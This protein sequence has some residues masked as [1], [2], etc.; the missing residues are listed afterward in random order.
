MSP[1]IIEGVNSDPKTCNNC[2][3]L[4]KS[5]HL[6]KNC[7]YHTGAFPAAKA[8][9]KKD[10]RVNT[11]LRFMYDMMFKAGALKRSE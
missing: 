7:G 2:G 6:C 4:R 10:R 9:P 5:L 1:P 3:E 8:T 11:A